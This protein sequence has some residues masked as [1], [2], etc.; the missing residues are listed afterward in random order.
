VLRGE[1]SDRRAIAAYYQGLGA[2]REHGIYPVTRPYVRNV[3]AL[4]ERLRRGWNPAV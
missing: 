3:V 4:R 2:V 1:T